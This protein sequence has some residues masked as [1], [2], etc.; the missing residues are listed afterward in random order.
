MKK[1]KFLRVAC[2]CFAVIFIFLAM[3]FSVA[4][5]GAV[6]YNILKF[7]VLRCERGDFV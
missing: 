3:P 2:L 4:K 1:T 6:W 7:T 5:R